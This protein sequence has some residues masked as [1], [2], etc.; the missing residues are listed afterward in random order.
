MVYYLQNIGPPEPPA[1]TPSVIISSST[2]LTISWSGSTYDGGSVVIGYIVEMKRDNSDWEV[3]TKECQCTSYIVR[4]LIPNC[5]Y[6]F[7]IRA[8]NV[9]GF[10]KASSVSD[11][12][13]LSVNSFPNQMNDEQ[14]MIN[15]I[16]V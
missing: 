9:H 2:S 16:I 7:R 12:V 3:I 15:G 5:I 8:I 4:N 13:K 10:S 14:N 1:G 11:A 6:S